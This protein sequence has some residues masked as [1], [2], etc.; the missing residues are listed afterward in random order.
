MKYVKTIIVIV[1]A[2]ILL[3]CLMGS[4]FDNSFVGSVAIYDATGELYMVY[5]GRIENL[6]YGDGYVDFEFEGEHY[7]YINN[8]IEIVH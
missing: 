5:A 3:I 4:A 7:T 8:F 6:R 2:V 1:L